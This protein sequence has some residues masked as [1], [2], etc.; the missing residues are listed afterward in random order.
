MPARFLY[1][2]GFKSSP[3]SRKAQ[4]FS[5]YCKKVLPEVEV[6]MPELSFNPELAIAQLEEIIASNEVKLI[7]GSSL[8]GY[9]A[10]WLSEKY[11]IRAALIN[12][13]V[14]PHRTLTESFLGLHTNMYTGQEFELT[15][16]HVKFLETLETEGIKIPENFLV[17]LQTGDTVLDY[18]HAA[19]KYRHCQVHV[20]E[21]GDHSFT[22]F[23]DVLPT[24]VE[25]SGFSTTN[26]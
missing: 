15:R 4:D 1:I 12:P 2:H 24:I 3:D 10:T 20:Y 6:I 19:E 25:F 17:L 23:K 18:R 16:E 13:A 5:A 11:D 21:G 26:T 9:F 8:G 14:D 22:L 7:V